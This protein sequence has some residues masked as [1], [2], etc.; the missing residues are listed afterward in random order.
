V[1]AEMFK[2]Y[3]QMMMEDVMIMDAKIPGAERGDLYSLRMENAVIIKIHARSLLTHTS[4]LKMMSYPN[5]EYLQALR[6][7]IE[8]F[9][10]LLVECVNNFDKTYDIEKVKAILDLFF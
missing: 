3:K 4:G 6:D 2:H 10:K 8:E 7:E 1:P 9:R 5:L